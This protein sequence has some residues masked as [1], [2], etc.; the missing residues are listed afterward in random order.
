MIEMRLKDGDFVPDGTGGFEGEREEQALLQR[1]LFK[2]TARRG[3]FPFL[4]ELGSYLHTLYREKESARQGLCARY[5]AQA[6]EG[7]DVTV[8]D[9]VYSCENGRAQVTVQL[10]WQGQRR[11][12]TAQIGGMKNEDSGRALR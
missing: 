8:R 9:V 3:T 4:P 2:L 5:V 1:I 7:E 12:I 11:E 10:D 6:L